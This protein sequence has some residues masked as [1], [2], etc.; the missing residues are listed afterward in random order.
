MGSVADG[1]AAAV[2]NA[3]KT[4]LQGQEIPAEMP[5]IP[6]RLTP[7]V[8]SL[9]KGS[10]DTSWYVVLSPRESRGLSGPFSLNQLK[11]MYKSQD[12]TDRTLVW[13]EGEEQWQQ[14]INQ[15]LLRSRLISLPIIPPRLGNYNKELAVFDPIVEMPSK[16]VIQRAVP[17]EGSSTDRTCVVCGNIAVAHIPGHGEQRYDLIKGRH[18]VGTNENASEI[19][20]G[21][22]WVGSSGASK[23]KFLHL[24]GITLLINCTDNFKNPTPQAPYFRCKDLPMPEKPS[25]T[26]S[27]IEIRKLLDGIEKVYD[28]I[29]NERLAPEKGRLSDA[30]PKYH[31]GAT[32]DFGFPVKSASDKP[33]RRP[34]VDATTPYAPPR[35]LLWSRLGTNRSVAVAAAY[36]IKQYGITL[37]RAVKILKKTRPVVNISPMYM[38]VLEIWS[39]RYSLGMLLCVDCM[40]LPL[41]EK[42]D[43]VEGGEKTLFEITKDSLRKHTPRVVKNAQ[44]GTML[45]DVD[46]YLIGLRVNY[47]QDSA[48]SK[49]MDLNL[50]DRRLSDAT[51]ASLCQLLGASGAIYH[52]RCINFSNNDI[53]FLTLKELLMA[54][55]PFA[56][57]PDDSMYFDYAEDNNKAIM[58]NQVI[59]LSMLDLSHNHIELQGMRYLT[60]LLRLSESVMWLSLFG[61]N[62]S[63]DTTSEILTCLTTP[64]FDFQSVRVAG[65]RDS[66]M[67]LQNPHG[68][69]DDF[70][71]EERAHSQSLGSEALHNRSVTYL[72][73]GGNYIQDKAAEALSQMLRQNVLLQTLKLEH[74]PSF[75]SMYFKDISNAIRLY[76][77]TL[78]HLFLS[79]TS[80]SVGAAKHIAHIPDSLDTRIMKLVLTKC[81]LH[82]LQIKAMVHGFS[83]SS[84]LKYLDLS[85]NPIGVE[86]TAALVSIVQGSKNKFSGKLCPPLEHLDLTK[87]NLE[88]LGCSQLMAAVAAKDTMTYLDLSYNNIGSA[89][90]AFVAA[91]RESSLVEAHFNYCH[92]HTSTANRLFHAL[93]GG[94]LRMVVPAGQESSTTSSTSTATE[95]MTTG[96]KSKAKGTAFLTVATGH[97]KDNTDVIMEE[98]ERSIT[99]LSADDDPPPYNSPQP[100]SHPRHHPP[101]TYKSK[102]S[103]TL[104]SFSLAGNDISDSAA[105]ALVEML[106]DNV[107]LEHLDLGFNNFTANA[108]EYFK[109]GT[110]VTSSST[111]ATKVFE[112]NINMVGNKCPAYALETPGLA[113]SKITFRFGTQPNPQDSSLLGY[114]HISDRVRGRFM[115]SK[116]L[117]DQFRAAFP[118]QTIHTLH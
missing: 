99:A 8:T 82:H 78:Q 3:V 67:M 56:V 36:L 20:P 41:D 22:L 21:L 92:L 27:D 81:S 70:D 74:C 59:E 28:A 13:K 14:L 97:N 32:D 114:A 38:S 64:M 113:R 35:I 108:M 104:R 26:F 34:D 62:M 45:R 30:T 89:N 66:F 2:E 18:E 12:I 47:F 40:Q 91:F 98:D 58:S 86:G 39:Q 109:L 68:N 46:R 116:A 115:A 73:L 71:D 75:S 31:R 79:G 83:T 95:S 107:L 42:K 5:I 96:V 53:H 77:A 23:H 106:R 51:L 111:A 43:D 25:T 57:D 65:N 44:E 101:P 94:Q 4:C 49:L 11:Q 76:N 50:S 72:D 60:S 84:Y 80:L 17:L 24:V 19:L 105:E 10:G 52:L 54:Y 112:L 103:N 110:K 37:S 93:K 88:P 63:D 48:W 33:F 102:V 87:C 55:F 61:N 9:P 117:D 1:T 118:E 90:D 69:D 15:S 29:E 16:K 7:V 85:Y 6:P 100:H